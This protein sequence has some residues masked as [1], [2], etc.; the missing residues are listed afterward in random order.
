M[1]SRLFIILCFF[2]LQAPD[3]LS[4]EEPVATS[5]EEQLAGQYY[6]TG[7]YEKAAQLYEK[8][9]EKT[10][11][12]FYYTQL[13]NCYLNLR[14]IKNAE[15]L[16]NRQ[17]RW[18]PGQPSYQVDL[19]NVY[20]QSGEED[21]AK[22]QFEKTIKSIDPHNDRQVMDLA[23]AFIRHNLRDYAIRTYL[24]ARKNAPRPYNFNLEL[25]E[26]YS[27]KG[28]LN[29]MLG[30]YSELINLHGYAYVE[31]IR[32]SLQDI[33]ASDVSGE[34]TAALRNYFIKEI[35]KTPDN[36]ILS[37]LLI[38]LYIQSKDFEAAF[39][40]TRALDKRLKEKGRRVLDLASLAAAND[41]WN[42]AKN[43]FQYV[44]D[45][46][47]GEFHTRARAELSTMLYRK[48]TTSV[49]YSDQDLD[50]LEALLYS[51]ITEIGTGI[52]SYTLAIR[53]AHLK[54][55]Y[56]NDAEKA[57]EVLAPYLQSQA[58][59]TP[60]ALNEVK[61]ELADIQLLI[62]DIWEATLTYS[63]VEKAMKTDTLGQE[64]KFRNA[65]LAYYKGDFEWAR[66]QLD[67]LKAA[68]SKLIAND[69]LEL[70]LLIGDNSVYDTTGEELRMYSRAD[71]ALYQNKPD[72]A[73]ATLD[74]LIEGY[75][76]T[77]LADEILY[78]KARIFI[79]KGRYEEATRSLETL[80]LAHRQ[81]ILADNALFLLAELNQ[82]QLN[83]PGK[84]MELYKELLTE[85]PGSLLVA[86][87]RRR[88]RQLRGDSYQ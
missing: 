5:T 63:Q 3:V 51:T 18:N 22:R 76:E 83:N 64:A 62:G 28:D 52:Q 67:I 15:K 23:T 13:L 33:I 79:R 47:P 27:A 43:A 10:P 40:Q 49:S 69:A 24:E 25:A 72:Q 1:L 9:Y 68:T 6:Q 60:R 32:I 39:T 86:E 82:D 2:L 7:E 42:T 71:L 14:D 17:A 84:A 30:E 12:A 57:L 37:D 75:P 8:L 85:F 31:H 46:G 16:V 48:L 21:K 77:T 73:I 70:S 36:L 61:M 80:L 66:A 50:E 38:W 20:K 59:L 74:S 11:V 54:A 26:L 87:A 56:R 55:F 4:Q 81:D 53:L 65:R 58:G 29:S 35:Q 44:I 45:L 78:L 88:F 19:G 41:Q 34:K